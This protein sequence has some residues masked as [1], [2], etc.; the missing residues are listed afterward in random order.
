MLQNNHYLLAHYEL[1]TFGLEQTEDLFRGQSTS[2]PTIYHPGNIQLN[3]CAI[4]FSKGLNKVIHCHFK[5][6]QLLGIANI[7]I[8]NN[9][10]LQLK[11]ARKA[12]LQKA[13]QNLSRLWKCH[14]EIGAT[15]SY[16]RN[17]LEM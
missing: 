3:K 13:L 6:Y 10:Y 17:I 8:T 14:L 5:C 4:V 7:G 11:S 15:C 9:Y 2:V 12:N 1:E 16:F